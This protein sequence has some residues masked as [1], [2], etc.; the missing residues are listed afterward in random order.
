LFLFDITKLGA[1]LPAVN[2]S[3][4]P[5]SC[6]TATYRCFLTTNSCIAWN[7]KKMSVFVRKSCQNCL[8]TVLLLKLISKQRIQGIK[9][10][11]RYTSCIALFGVDTG[12]FCW[13][14]Q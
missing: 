4:V 5:I 3:S 12:G 7:L 9:H 1:C 6:Y 14:S 10:Q 11:K 2:K 8:Q 13:T